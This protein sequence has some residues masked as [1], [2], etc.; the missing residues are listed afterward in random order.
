MAWQG[1]ERRRLGQERVSIRC[2][3]TVR[4]G[5]A[6]GEVRG[7]AL[8]LSRGG[9]MLNLSVVPAQVEVAVTLH[10]SKRPPVS[11]PAIVRWTRRASG[12]A[13]WRLGLTFGHELPS[14]LVQ[15]LAALAV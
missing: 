11:R 9:A 14:V 1:T 2:P 6:G 12:S 10:P 8:S 4:L 3:V 7:E 13:N 5:G 15:E